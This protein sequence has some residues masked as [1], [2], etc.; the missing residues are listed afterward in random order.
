MLGFCEAPTAKTEHPLIAA[1]KK[2]GGLFTGATPAPQLMTGSVT[3]LRI[4]IFTMCSACHGS[5][6]TAI[7]PLR[8]AFVGRSAGVLTVKVMAP[9][10]FFSFGRSLMKAIESLAAPIFSLL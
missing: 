8:K 7:Q 2:I 4:L 3:L 1:V 9:I 6:Q 5:H 10:S